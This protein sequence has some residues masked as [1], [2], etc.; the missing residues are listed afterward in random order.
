M[1]SKV[2]QVQWNHPV[3]DDWTLTVQQDLKD[4]KMNLSLEEIK[5]K[6]EWSFKRL[7]KTKSKEYAL[8]HLL[9]MKHNHSKMGNL[10]YEGLKIQN[11]LK[12]G[13]ITVKEAQNLFKYRTKVA[14]FKE[15][16]KNNYVESGCPLCHDQPDTQAHCVQCPIVKE[17]VN[18]KGDYSEI[19]SEEISKEIA[20][21][22][23]EISKFR[24]NK[25]LSPVGGPSAS[26]DAAI[27]CRAN[28][29]LIE[30]G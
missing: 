8:S 27:R 14:R 6:T 9:K 28:V 10:Q 1:L 21:T 12:N 5:E 15:N 18:I 13:N 30:L 20:Q 11:Y 3:K 29:H 22:L 16:F 17:N 23:L 19:F 4:F 2:F 25:T 24:E 7:V 26:D